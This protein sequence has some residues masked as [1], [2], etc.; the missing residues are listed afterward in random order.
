MTECPLKFEQRLCQLGELEVY[1]YEN[2]RFLKYLQISP[3]GS[4]ILSVDD[5]STVFTFDISQSAIKS[6]SYY[7]N[8]L[9]CDENNGSNSAL[10]ELCKKSAVQT[11]DTIFDAKWYPHMTH[12]NPS[13]NCYATSCRDHPI[14][15]WDTSSCQIRASYS[16]FDQYDELDSACSFVFNLTGDKIYSGTNRVIRY[17]YIMHNNQC[18]MIFTCCMMSILTKSIILCRIFDL[19]YP[20]RNYT[21]LQLCKTK[22]D[23]LGQKG[24]I[25]CMAFNPDYSKTYAVG[26]Y[27]NNVGMYVE[28]MNECALELR[29]LNIGGV[30]CV[31]WS[32]CG[33]MIWIGGR[34]CDAISC[35]DVRK[36]QKELGRVSRQL[37][38]NQKM[39]FDIDPWGKYLA[40]GT[41]NGHILTYD[42]S[43]FKL[44]QDY[45]EENIY[46]K[47]SELKSSLKRKR[48]DDNSQSYFNDDERHDDCKLS[49]DCTNSISFHPYS[50]ILV[51]A[52]GQRHFDFNNNPF[53]IS[54]DDDDSD[55][56]TKDACIKSHLKRKF[57]SGI[58]L[59][60]IDADKLRR[61]EL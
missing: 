6:H 30:S 25:S 23:Y 12:D 60:K 18:M 1:A 13:T 2:C 55:A 26:S 45:N 40:T 28:D 59:W 38:T 35:W 29:D 36:T 5:D 33:R 54:D 20:G 11:G 42:T 7:E 48:D 14:H 43:E 17:V 53:P 8:E 50:S 10:T 24:I 9:H 37:C 52:T 56:E 15:L 47:S 58:Q 3:D 31:K 41:Q 32:P 27:A 49:L 19:S 21:E 4:Q 39:S 34:N 22:H 46:I 51:S 57:S 44:I 16:G 61:N